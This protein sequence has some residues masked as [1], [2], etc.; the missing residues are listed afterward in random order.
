MASCVPQPKIPRHGIEAQ[1]GSQLLRHAR[2]FAHAS[3][4]L[5]HRRSLEN[6]RRA[7]SQL[8]PAFSSR[9]LLAPDLIL[10]LFPHRG[11][12][13]PAD[14]GADEARCGRLPGPRHN[15]GRT[16]PICILHSLFVFFQARAA[17]II[18]TINLDDNIINV[19]VSAKNIF[20]RLSSL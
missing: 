1:A 2:S 8:D 9:V 18:Y 20:V 17:S 3:T 12:S 13:L 6:T 11:V 14:V 4:R 10:S 19:N 7:L 15:T 5:I 16:F